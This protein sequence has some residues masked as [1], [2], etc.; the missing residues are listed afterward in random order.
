M[1][2]IPAIDRGLNPG[3]LA[4]KGIC[5]PVLHLGQPYSPSILPPPNDGRSSGVPRVR[6]CGY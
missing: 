3:H 2:P 6:R 5:S 1:R 4:R